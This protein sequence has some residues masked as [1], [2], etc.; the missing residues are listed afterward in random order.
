V[1]YVLFNTFLGGPYLRIIMPWGIDQP[2]AM[3]NNETVVDHAP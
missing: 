2:L 3:G 1:I